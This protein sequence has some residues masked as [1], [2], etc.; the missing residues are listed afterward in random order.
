MRKGAD[1]VAAWL[2]YVATC[3]ALMA[4][5]MWG[6]RLADFTGLGAMAVSLALTVGVVGMGARAVKGAW[7]P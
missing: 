5:F 1:R 4:A 3:A 7:L 6:F 2:L